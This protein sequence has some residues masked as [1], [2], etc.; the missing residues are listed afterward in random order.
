MNV[1]PGIVSTRT[2]LLVYAVMLL[3]MWAVSYLSHTLRVER[4]EN[5]RM[6]ENLVANCVVLEQMGES[7]APT[8]EDEVQYCR[9]LMGGLLADERWR[10]IDE[11]VDIITG[12]GASFHPSL[13]DQRESPRA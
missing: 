8:L 3:G 6:G 1:R 13:L 12:A 5:L 4:A 2:T 10:Q 11:L 9:R 7:P